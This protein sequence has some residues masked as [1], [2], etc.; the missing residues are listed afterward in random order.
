MA[1]EYEIISY[2]SIADPAWWNKEL[3]TKNI[4][5]ANMEEGELVFNEGSILYFP[6]ENRPAY[7][8]RAVNKND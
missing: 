2:D 5:F 4:E 1:V 8:R 6:Q 7:I 3:S